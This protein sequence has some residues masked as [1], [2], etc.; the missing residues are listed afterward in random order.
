MQVSQTGPVFG[1]FVNAH[2]FRKLAAKA[3]RGNWGRIAAVLSPNGKRKVK[4]AWKHTEAKPTHWWDVPGIQR[5]WNELVSGE[6]DV[7]A[8][9]YLAAKYLAGREG[10]VAMSLACGT[11]HR[12]IEW[13]KLGVFERLDGF[14]LSET[15]IEHAKRRAREEGL[16]GVLDFRVADVYELAGDKGSYDVVIAEQSLHHFAPMRKILGAIDDLLREEGLF[17]IDEYVGPTRFQWTDDQLAQTN[18]LLGELPE[19]YRVQWHDGRV[20]EA[21]VRPSKLSM[22]LQ[23]PSEAVD[24]AE[25]L[26][27]L[28]EVFDVLEV[29]EYGG[30]L[31]HL[32]FENIAHN[33]RGDDGET[34]ELL[35]RCYAAEDEL[36]SDGK[37][38]SDF[39]V[40]ACRK[41]RK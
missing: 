22:I 9:A 24:S 15:R 1:N 28:R 38:P 6:P 18:R 5:R 3:R 4:E 27:G 23:D 20:R 37:L 33:F 13:A 17:L 41:R 29:R 7:D 36:L 21:A 25:I 31:L 26:P 39:V 32:L 8:R 14:D 10:L 40:A 35:R 2:D 19:R 11:G 12:E 34:R 16:D 30:T